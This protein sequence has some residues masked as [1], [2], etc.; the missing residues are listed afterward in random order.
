MNSN[1][2]NKYVKLGLSLAFVAGAIN[3]GG[4][5]AVSRYTSHM[6]GITS[7]IA[8][9][10]VIGDFELVK[11]LVF[12]LFSFLFGAIY[13]SLVINWGRKINLKDEFILCIFS[14]LVLMTLFFFK[15]SSDNIIFYSCV[16][17]FIMGLQN[18]VVTKISN[19]TIRTTHVT[20]TLTDIGIQLGRAIFNFMQIFSKNKKVVNVDIYALKL[21]C[22]TYFMF[23]LGGLFG[24]FGFK[25]YQEYFV[26][27]ICVIL[28][29]ICLPSVLYNFKLL[30]VLKNRQKNRV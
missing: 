3:A 22:G 18:S 30:N 23:I 14:E 2:K 11:I 10:I 6:T 12:Y 15:I 21:L 26:L 20:G 17:C 28:A 27:P 8:D 25:F 9:N 16:L 19:F 1:A 29:I 7:E 4:F 13:S 24:A 5:F